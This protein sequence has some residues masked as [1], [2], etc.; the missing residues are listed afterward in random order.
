MVLKKGELIARMEQEPSVNA[1]GV[2][3][4]L[5]G[6]ELSP[7]DKETLWN[8]VSEVGDHTSSIEKEQLFSLLV[9]Y[10]DVFSFHDSGCRSHLSH[11]TQNRNRQCLCCLLHP[12][13]NSSC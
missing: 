8:M 7:E 12:S 11:R 1:V 10:G 9:A 13:E 4:S 3:G 5:A 6:P 2:S